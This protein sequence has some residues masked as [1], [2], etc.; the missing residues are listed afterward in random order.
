MKRSNSTLEAPKRGMARKSPTHGRRGGGTL[1][2]CEAKFGH[3]L[4]AK[5]SKESK[6]SK[7]GGGFVRGDARGHLATCVG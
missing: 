3:L 7:E 1:G 6:E 4:R 5:E 2:P